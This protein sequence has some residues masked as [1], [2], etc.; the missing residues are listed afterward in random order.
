[1]KM[2]HF[3]LEDDVDED[4]PVVVGK[5]RDERAGDHGHGGEREGSCAMVRNVEDR[6]GTLTGNLNVCDTKGE[7]CSFPR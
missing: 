2:K 4:V 3:A 6:G 1:M 7:S 5:D